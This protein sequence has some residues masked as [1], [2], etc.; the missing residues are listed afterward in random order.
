MEIFKTIIKFL[1]D[2]KIT[3]NVKHEI[4]NIFEYFYETG[5]LL[6]NNKYCKLSYRN[7]FDFMDYFDNCNGFEII[8]YGNKCIVKCLWNK[9][10]ICNM[11][12]TV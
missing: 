7:G 12:I 11:F 5:E 3:E 1:D 9:K 2:N 10:I 8:T 4:L 6:H